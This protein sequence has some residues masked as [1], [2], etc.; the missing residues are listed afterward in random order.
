[1]TETMLVRT[2][3]GNWEELR[4]QKKA[5]AGG[6]VELFGEDLGPVLGLSAPL[7]VAAC[8]PVLPSGSPDVICID[9]EGSLAVVTMS[10]GPAADDLL[11]QLLAHAGSLHGMGFGEFEGLCNRTAQTSGALAAFMAE[12][13]GPGFHDGTFAVTVADAL[14][15]GRFRLVAL[16]G[17][18]PSTLVQSIRYLNASGSNF[19][20]FQTAVFSSASVS[21]IQARPL[22]VGHEHQAPV[23]SEMTAAG[24]TAITERTCD[25]RIARLMGQLQTYC[26][27]AFDDVSYSGDSSRAQF[28]ARLRHGNGV[29]EVLTA[30]SDGTVAISFESLA[31]LDKG[32]SVRGA[33]CEATSRLLGADLGDVKKISQ[34]NLSIGEHLMDATLM[35]AFMEILGDT[36]DSVQGAGQSKRARSAVAA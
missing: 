25:E 29:A 26:A 7:I 30:S 34:L 27:G 22:D 28:T 2:H 8:E 1:M 15:H 9:A 6:V 12:R 31:V 13:G 23:I 32:W 3:S 10:L 18:A 20:L 36:L 35:E 11:A 21:A 14:N 19:S 5:P 17:S 4:P 24:L 16:V 33:L